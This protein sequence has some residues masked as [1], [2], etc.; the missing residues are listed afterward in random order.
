MAIVALLMGGAIGMMAFVI[1]LL[2]GLPFGTSARVYFATGAATV[3]ALCLL[4]G[5][6]KWRERTR[7]DSG[8]CGTP[9][10]SR[11]R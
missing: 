10:L 9:A 1:S 3:I 11:R 6:L 2:I 7:K 8:P 5:A 4:R